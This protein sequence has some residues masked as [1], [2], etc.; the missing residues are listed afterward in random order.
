[1]LNEKNKLFCPHCMR[2]KKG[3]E[4]KKDENIYYCFYCGFMVEESWIRSVYEFVR[5]KLFLEEN[6]NASR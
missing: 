5:N 4:L 1:M 6:T 2:I 3:S